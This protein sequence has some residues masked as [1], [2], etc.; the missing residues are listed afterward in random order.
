[1]FWHW[2]TF[3]M[4]SRTF[5]TFFNKILI[6]KGKGG[7]RR[8]SVDQLSFYTWK[9]LTIL[10]PKRPSNLFVASDFIGILPDGSWIG[11]PSKK[12]FKTLRCRFFP[13][14]FEF[15]PQSELP[16]I[17]QKW[18]FLVWQFFVQQ[19]LPLFLQV[20]KELEQEQLVTSNSESTSNA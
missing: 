8:E 7:Q 17:Y 13:L 1:M 3:S 5:V 19:H 20:P 18:S 9:F 6:L 10:D 11:F 2:K 12:W 14:I 16:K 4:V 15:F